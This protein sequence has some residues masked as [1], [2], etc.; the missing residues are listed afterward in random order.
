[1][2]LIEWMTLRGINNSDGDEKVAAKLRKLDPDRPCSASAVKKW[3]YQERE[4]DALRILHIEKITK[5]EVAL[6]DWAAVRSAA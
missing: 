6:R 2:Q 3:K 5:G 1:M 4:P